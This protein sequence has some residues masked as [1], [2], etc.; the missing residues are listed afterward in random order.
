MVYVIQVMLTASEQDHDGI[1][2]SLSTF[3]IHCDFTSYWGFVPKISSYFSGDISV[4]KSF[5]LL[6]FF[7]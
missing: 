3:V 7:V 2:S 5:S 6:F 1:L 4:P